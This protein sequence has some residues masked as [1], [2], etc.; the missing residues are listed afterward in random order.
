[1]G[2]GSWG[3]AAST[4]MYSRLLKGGSISTG[5]GGPDDEDPFET[6]A[7]LIIVFGFTFV[8]LTIIMC[9]IK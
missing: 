9:L 2:A 8:I 5:T 1:M 6:L 3:G 4:L 7:K